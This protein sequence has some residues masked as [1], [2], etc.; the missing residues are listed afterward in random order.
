MPLLGSFSLL[1]MVLSDP[2]GTSLGFSK[3]LSGKESNCNVENLQEIWV[4]VLGQ[5]DA[6]EGE[7][8]TYSHYSCL[9]NSMDRE[10]CRLQSM[11]Q[12]V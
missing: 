11:S 9:E 8:A 5:E 10:T 12:G 3:L 1:D 2:Q 4:Q 7:M 6:L